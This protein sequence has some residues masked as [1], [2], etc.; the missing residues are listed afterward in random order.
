MSRRLV[1]RRYDTDHRP[2]RTQ[3]ARAGDAP[4]RTGEADFDFFAPRFRYFACDPAPARVMRARA[5]GV[6]EWVT[7]VWCRDRLHAAFAALGPDERRAV[8]FALASPQAVATLEE[9]SRRAVENVH[10]PP[11]I[12]SEAKSAR[13]VADSW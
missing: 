1:A 3:A 13:T 2:L 9:P 4:A 10:G 7:R 5:P 6:Y 12:R 11:P 8:E